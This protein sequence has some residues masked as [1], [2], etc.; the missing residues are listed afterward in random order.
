MQPSITSRS[1]PTARMRSPTGAPYLQEY[2]SQVLCQHNGKNVQQG[3]SSLWQCRATENSD[4]AAPII[5]RACR[6]EKFY[7]MLQNKIGGGK[8]KMRWYFGEGPS[9]PLPCT[10]TV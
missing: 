8:P 1:S 2:L 3:W 5:P 10:C 9:D 6:S 7:D 4:S